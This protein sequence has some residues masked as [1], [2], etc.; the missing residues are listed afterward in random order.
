MDCS[1]V[2]LI[3]IDFLLCVKPLTLVYYCLTCVGSLFVHCKACL[4]NDCRIL[5][6]ADSKLR[7]YVSYGQCTCY[8]MSVILTNRRPM[9]ILK[10][11]VSE[12]FSTNNL[13]DWLLDNAW[14]YSPLG[15]QV[16][17]WSHWLISLFSNTKCFSLQWC[18]G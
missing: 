1:A 3:I 8:F 2:L 18:S 17:G 9:F 5:R 6:P 11:K 16:L 14:K 4:I 10:S 13:S 12:I 7:K 15:I